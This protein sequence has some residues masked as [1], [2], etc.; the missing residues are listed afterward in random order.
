MSADPVVKGTRGASK[1]REKV[2]WDEV[3]G[4]SW[5]CPGSVRAARVQGT[6]EKMRQGHH[7]ADRHWY[8][9]GQWPEED[10]C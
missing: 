7:D 5:L 8:P 2:G 10:A 1:A 4:S 3:R 6:G 9:L